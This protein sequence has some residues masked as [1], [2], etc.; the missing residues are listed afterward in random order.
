MNMTQ[1]IMDCLRQRAPQMMTSDQIAE[2]C[3]VDKYRVPMLLAW[4]INKGRVCKS[5]ATG[6]VRYGWVDQRD[7]AIDKAKSL[8]ISA[9]Y[10]VTAA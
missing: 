2:A 3:G 7:L 4:H 10:R 8:L 9:G 6:P 5:T 1:I